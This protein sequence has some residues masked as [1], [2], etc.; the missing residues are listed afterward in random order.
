MQRIL[1]IEDD[2][3]VKRELEA[4]LEKTDT[5]RWLRLRVN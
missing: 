4:L 2:E 3:A 5:A 1:V